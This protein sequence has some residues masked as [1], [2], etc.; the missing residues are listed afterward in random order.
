M[1]EIGNVC[2]KLMTALILTFILLYIFSLF[3][4]FYKKMY[5]QHA[6]SK[7]FSMLVC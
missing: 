6:H 3:H 5:I 2:V 1:T 4:I 7:K